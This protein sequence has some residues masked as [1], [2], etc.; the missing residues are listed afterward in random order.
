MDPGG[1]FGQLSSGAAQ[2]LAM[3]ACC[4]GPDLATPKDPPLLGAEAVRNALDGC[5][6]YLRECGYLDGSHRGTGMYKRNPRI[7]GAGPRYSLHRQYMYQNRYRQALPP[8][9]KAPSVAAGASNTPVFSP[10]DRQQFLPCFSAL[11][12]SLPVFALFLLRSL[13]NTGKLTVQ[14]RLGLAS[15]QIGASGLAQKHGP[16]PQAQT[17]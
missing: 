11:D 4:R 12:H 6:K 7:A 14:A 17:A 5:W 16:N 10:S 2:P 15:H 3:G 1:C 8:G 13:N 9:R